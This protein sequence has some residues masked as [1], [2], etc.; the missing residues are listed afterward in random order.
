MPSCSTGLLG[1]S[2]P[3]AAAGPELGGEGYSVIT[4]RRTQLNADSRT[5]QWTEPW[6]EVRVGPLGFGRSS[7]PIQPWV[8]T[9][10]NFCP[11][12]KNLRDIPSLA[13]RGWHLSQAV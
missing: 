9:A 2:G 12:E 7:R 3:S 8:F 10:E 4:S 5:S 6:R 13:P 11:V 1:P